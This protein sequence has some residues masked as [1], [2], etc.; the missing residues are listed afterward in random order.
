LPPLLRDRRRRTWSVARDLGRVAFVLTVMRRAGA[1]FDDAWPVALPSSRAHRD[2]CDL[3]AAL[4]ATEEGWRRAYVGEP[5]ER[6]EVAA[7]LL[8]DMLTD[9]DPEP[10]VELVGARVG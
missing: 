9:R 4:A 10:S 2:R 6:A 7:S 3:R 5:A 1:S 8:L